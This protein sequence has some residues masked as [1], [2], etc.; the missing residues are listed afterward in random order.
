MSRF[1]CAC[2]VAAD[3]VSSCFARRATDHRDVLMGRALSWSATLRHTSIIDGDVSSRADM[4]PNAMAGAAT[5]A[6]SNDLPPAAAAFALS[7]GVPDGAPAPAWAG[8]TPFF[9]DSVDGSIL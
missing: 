6:T 4:H 2:S 1:T 8:A 7:H 9:F 5:S 3:S